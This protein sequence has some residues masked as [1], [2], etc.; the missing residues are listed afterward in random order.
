M[1]GVLPLLAWGIGGWILLGEGLGLRAAPEAR[2]LTMPEVFLIALSVPAGRAIEGTLRLPASEGEVVVR[3]GKG[4]LGVVWAIG[5][6][7][8]NL[9]VFPLPQPPGALH[10]H[11]ERYRLL[12]LWEGRVI[13]ETALPAAQPG[14]GQWLPGEGLEEALRLQPIEP[15]YFT[16]DFMRTQEQTGGWEVVEGQWQV[17][18]PKSPRPNPRLSANPFAYRAEG[19]GRH[20]S[21]AGLPFWCERRFLVAVKPE[22]W[23]SIGALLTYLSADHYL[24]FRWTTPKEGQGKVEWVSRWK[25]QEKILASAPLAF[26]PGVWYA[27]ELRH[28]GGEAQALVDGRLV[29]R[30]PLEGPWEG[31]V[32]LFSEG[33]SA[34]FDDVEVTPWFGGREEFGSTLFRWWPLQGRWT[35]GQGQ[36][37]GVNARGARWAAAIA[38]EAWWSDYVFEVDITPRAG[39]AGVMVGSEDGER[40]YQ[41]ALEGKPPRVRMVYR[42]GDREEPLAEAPYPFPPT[43]RQRWR[44]SFLRGH[45][46][47]TIGGR[48]LLEAI[49]HRIAE[50]GVVLWT[51]GEAAFA[52][53]LLE[54]S[55][56]PPPV[57]IAEQF[58]K[59]KTMEQWASPRGAWRERE[60]FHWHQGWFLNDWEIR[61]EIPT[62]QEGRW[63]WV[64]APQPQ[65]EK[66]IL[67]AEVE[68]KPGETLCWVRMVPG[69]EVPWQPPQGDRVRLRL[70]RRGRS[71]AL[72][73]VEGKT[74]V[75]SVLPAGDGR[76]I[77]MRVEKWPIP[78]EALSL[79]AQGLYDYTFSQ[80]PTDWY[81]DR[82]LW[83]IT[84][85]WR[86]YPG[87][88]WFGGT[89]DE[90]PILWSKRVFRGDVLVEAYAA[91][92]MDNDRGYSRPSDLNLTLFGDGRTLGTGYSF[93]FGGWNNTRSGIWRRDRLL[94]Q[95]E[96]VK[97]ENPTTGNE[98]FHRHWFYLRVERR[99]PRL[100]YWVDN[101]LVA[102]MED[103]EPLQE[104]RVAFWTWRNGILLA[105]VRIWAQEG[106][107]AVPP[108]TLPEL[109]PPPASSKAPFFLWSPTHTFV[110]KTFEGSGEGVEAMDP[111]AVALVLLPQGGPDG[112][113]A[114][115]AWQRKAGSPMAVRLLKTPFDARSVGRLSFDL[116][117]APEVGLNLYLRL[118]QVWHTVR[119]TGPEEAW[120]GGKLLGKAMPILADGR[121]HKVE[122]PLASLLAQEMKPDAPWMVEE[123][124]LGQF[125]GEEYRVAGLGGIPW[126]KFFDLDNLRLEVGNGSHVLLCWRPAED[127]IYD[128]Y[129][130]SLDRNPRGEPKG[131]PRP[132]NAFLQQNL[133]PGQWFFHLKAH[134][135]QGDWTPTLHWPIEVRER[136]GALPPGNG[137]GFYPTGL[138]GTYYADPGLPPPGP[139]FTRQVAIRTEARLDFT[140]GP[141]TPPLEGVGP[142]YW[143]VRWEARIWLPKEGTYRFF[144]ENLDDA[145]RLYVDGKKVLEAWWLQPAQNYASEPLPLKAGEHALRVEFH[146]GPGAASIRLAWEGPGWQKEVIPLLKDFSEEDPLRRGVMGEGWAG[147]YFEDPDHDLVLQLGIEPLGPFFQKPL[148]RRVDPRLDFQWAQGASPLP[149]MPPQFWSV[150]WEGKL[151]VPRTEEYTFFLENLDDAGRL[152]IDGQLVIDAWKVQQAAT[153]ISPPIRLEAGLHDI[154]VEY[155]QFWGLAGGIRL[156]WSAPSLPKEVIP[157]CY[158]APY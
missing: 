35:V 154:K 137:R 70:E 34:V 26:E 114:L 146:Q 41:V 36:L 101:R 46:T 83:E 64:L 25:G 106:G 107:E 105:R 6:R 67:R 129:L 113:T 71:L 69:P 68:R 15:P 131:T 29:L 143:S 145:A 62:R 127:E 115:R 12:A 156:G 4:N 117:L 80:A 3:L 45:L 18:G 38:G 110:F 20:L 86:C 133:E 42:D 7:F 125:G 151:L 54:A 155:H 74:L 123:V 48:L 124:V 128:G 58:T 108:P 77:G 65:P 104:G 153:H 40:G 59:E 157:P 149:G 55:P 90:A 44:I 50:G 119:L 147:V 53:A 100:T 98:G 93:L 130:W 142:D 118:G 92:Q 95:N 88:S 60:N 79:W 56:P 144:L 112:S 75:Q 22:G 11:R 89:Q 47:V 87:W 103:T 39:D 121:W 73:E 99:G 49:D 13:G 136:A 109:P 111:S 27:L 134:R 31:R 91:I 63:E 5:G 122:I 148:L 138:V 9:A 16:D 140:W 94:A 57:E 19:P 126:G 96:Q 85:R 8:V 24:L 23:G 81:P 152:F 28:A 150:R 102:E 10:L 132:E 72:G 21:V 158:E 76:C 43:S 116:R 66:A 1:R 2:S 61:F 33:T 51:T 120:G 135:Y 84:D 97:I 78:W 52:R 30:A 32:G 139:C 37:V 141:G 14:Q 82:G 17:T